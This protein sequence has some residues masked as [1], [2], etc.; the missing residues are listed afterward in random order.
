MVIIVVASAI[1]FCCSPFADC[2]TPSLPN[3]RV[4]SIA[5]RHKPSCA[6]PGDCVAP[7]AADRGCARFGGTIIHV[8]PCRRFNNDNNT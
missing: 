2:P 3:F 8:L 7:F 4:K 6:R 5:S 1:P